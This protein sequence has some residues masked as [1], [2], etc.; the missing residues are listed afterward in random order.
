MDFYVVRLDGGNQRLGQVLMQS[1]EEALGEITGRITGRPADKIT[2]RPEG[3]AAERLADKIIGRP[4]D[5]M[6]GVPQVERR[7]EDGME[8]GPQAERPQVRLLESIAAFR[9]AAEDGSMRGSRVLFAAGLPESGISM[10]LMKVLSYLHLHTDALEGAVGGIVVDGLGDWFTKDAGRRIAFAMTMSGCTLPGKSLVEATASLGNFDV[11]A[12]TTHT[13]NRVAYGNS[14]RNLILKI[15]FFERETASRPRILAVHASSRK[16]SNSLMLWSMVRRQLEGMADIEEVS[17]R[18]GQVWDCRGCKYETC[19]HFGENSSCFYGGVMV[20]KV[21]PAIVKSDVVV[22]IC[23]NYND[24]V[25]ANIMAFINRLTAVFRT[26][27]FSRKR[28]YAI[29]VSGYSGGDIVTQQIIGAMNMNKNFIL[30]GHFALTETANDPGSILRLPD[31]EER[32]IALSQN[33]LGKG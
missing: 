14:V 13:T 29:V 9:E 25:S 32:A 31:I 7:P 3:R 10:E 15:L 27:D 11:Q 12:R 33:I 20:E 4:E 2:G 1:L 16:T 18:N 5:G 17:I 8:G 22:L 24:S 23:P 30:P 19:L 26:N 6:E 28:V 21:Y